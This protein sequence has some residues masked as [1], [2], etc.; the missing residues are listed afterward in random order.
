MRVVVRFR[1]LTEESVGAEEMQLSLPYRTMTVRDVVREMVVRRSDL[2][3]YLSSKATDQPWD[4]IV[5]VVNGRVANPDDVLV[6]GDVVTLLP[7]MNGG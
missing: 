1:C 3:C 5:T 4:F 6:D 7:P 2:L